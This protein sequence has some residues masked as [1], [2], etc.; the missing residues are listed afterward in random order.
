MVSCGIGCYFHSFFKVT[1]M[2]HSLKDQHADSNMKV[3]IV[4]AA[5]DTFLK[6]VVCVRVNVQQCSPS[7]AYHVVSRNN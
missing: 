1:K 4:M 6:N 5:I 7:H 2:S 3:L